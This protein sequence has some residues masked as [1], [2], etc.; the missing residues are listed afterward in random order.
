MLQVEDIP[1]DQRHLL[2]SGI[3]L[4]KV[5]AGSP[6][7]L[8]HFRNLTRYTRDESDLPPRMRELAL[9]QIGFT[10][11]CAYEYAHHLKAALSAGVTAAEIRAIADESAG[12][13]TQFDEVTRATL[14]AARDLTSG[15]AV[16]RDAFDTLRAAFGDEI[17]ID[18]V[19]A[20]ISYTA[21]V[22][23]LET[24]EVDLEDEYYP[25]LK[26]FPLP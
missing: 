2:S 11:R 3:N 5:M 13:P 20:I 6:R 15:F 19:I 8:S 24:F 22:R 12:R 25:Y 10:S 26:Q 23:F 16:A 21:T 1:A 17:L 7:A 4:H 14:Q 18:L 9:V